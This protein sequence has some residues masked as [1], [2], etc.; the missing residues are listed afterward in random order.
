MTTK[1]TK[2]KM[3]R[4][5]RRERR[6]GRHVPRKRFSQH[7]LAPTWAQKVAA[8][9][10]PAAGDV[11]VEIGPGTGALTLPLA[12]TGAPILAVEID[13][14]LS[15]DLAGRVP[16]N[17]TVYSGDFLHVDVL[18]LLS[19]LQPQRP[20][21]ASHQA[22]VPRRFRIVGNLP[23]HLSSPMIAYLIRLHRQTGMFADATL[24]LQR[25]VADRLVARP[26]THDYGSLSVL[27]Q[28]HTQ[29][30]RLLE[31]PPG[32]FTP[33]P[34][35][36]SS[37]IRLEFRPPV[38]RVSDE[39]GFERLVKAL[40]SQR[41]KTLLNAL[42]RFDQTGAA[43]LAISGLD[44]RRRPETLQVTEIAGL[45]ELFASVRRGAVL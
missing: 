39:P 37:L 13:R 40:F 35:V 41:R 33:P 34:N 9:V 8:A 20:A 5:T 44:G 26:A 11:F 6:P 28:M 16:S 12:A 30:T 23:Y 7:F 17:V 15:R 19:G 2:K 1:T 36:R 31:L 43:V 18:P 14:D 24:M 21:D 22:H 29:C 42:K 10:Q 4:T 45:A 3:P 32:A 25:E 27:V 38:A